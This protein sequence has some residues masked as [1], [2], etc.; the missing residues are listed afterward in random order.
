LKTTGALG[1]AGGTALAVTLAAAAEVA[2]V[3]TL[4]TG[5]A[6]ATTGSCSAVEA[7]VGN[8]SESVGR[9]VRVYVKVAF[10]DKFMRCSGRK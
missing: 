9:I 8:A 7:T 1:A 10:D 2:A 3:L 4:E 6:V 5:A